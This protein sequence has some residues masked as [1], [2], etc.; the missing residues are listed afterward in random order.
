VVFNNTDHL[1]VLGVRNLLWTN[2]KVFWALISLPEAGEESSGLWLEVAY[3]PWLMCPSSIF[4]V[5]NDE[6]SPFQ[7]SLLCSS[8]PPHIS[9]SKIL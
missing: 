6:S 8:L 9:T 1:V 4:E 2:I 7:I 5:T 3:V